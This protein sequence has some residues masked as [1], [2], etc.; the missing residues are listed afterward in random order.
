MPKMQMVAYG[1]QEEYQEGGV[2]I[3]SKDLFVPIFFWVVVNVVVK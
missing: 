2:E 3:V 1:G